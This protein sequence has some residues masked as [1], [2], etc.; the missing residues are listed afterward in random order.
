M[1]PALKAAQARSRGK[2]WLKQI[3]Y[4]AQ[5][6]IRAILNVKFGLCYIEN[7]SVPKDPSEDRAVQ[8][9]RLRQH[10]RTRRAAKH[11]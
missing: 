5:G 9:D 8:K 3:V 11:H 7:R 4:G 6:Y 1:A 2:R 10:V